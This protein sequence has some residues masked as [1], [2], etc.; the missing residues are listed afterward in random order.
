MADRD[1]NK[2][3]WGGQQPGGG[4]PYQ[5]VYQPGPAPNYA[6]V[7]PQPPQY[8]QAD[9]KSPYEGD[10]FKPKK[11]LNDPFFLLFFI[12]QVRFQLCQRY[13]TL[14]ARGYSSQGS[15][16]F[17]RLRSRH[18]S[19]MAGLVGVSAAATQGALLHSTS[20]SCVSQYLNPA[21]EANSVVAEAI[22]SFYSYSLPQRPWCCLLCTSCLSEHSRG[23]LCTLHSSYP[24]H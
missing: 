15:S 2:D 8:A 1:W 24:S 22:Q 10:R 11:R 23:L 4:G 12:L 14:T 5:P 7:Q 16:S 18:G 19:R 6:Q 20:K 9:Q 17:L 21:S 3:Q 13:V